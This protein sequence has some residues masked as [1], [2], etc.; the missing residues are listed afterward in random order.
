MLQRDMSGVDMSGVDIRTTARAT[1]KH[2][3][4]QRVRH[5]SRGSIK[6]QN[7]NTQKHPHK[8]LM[9][10]THK[11]FARLILLGRTKAAVRLLTEQSSNEP[12]ECTPDTITQL[13]HK[14]P[15]AQTPPHCSNPTIYPHCHTYKSQIH[16]SPKQQEHC[17]VDMDLEAQTPHTGQTPSSGTVHR[18][19]QLQPSRQSL[20]TKTSAGTR[21]RH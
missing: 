1:P 14:L 20:Q 6:V 2:V 21:H 4:E 16:T 10:T 5:A 9:T 12:I 11:R 19:T 8:P 7:S 3:G 18:A 13:K 17:K 15:P